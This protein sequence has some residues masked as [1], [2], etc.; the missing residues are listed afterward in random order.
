MPRAEKTGNIIIIKKESSDEST[1][2]KIKK[3]KNKDADVAEVLQK[4]L[5]RIE[6]IEKRLGLR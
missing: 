5:E 4:I 1:K 6:A 2:D 3:M